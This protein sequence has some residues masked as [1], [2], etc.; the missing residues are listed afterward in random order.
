MVSFKMLNKISSFII[1]GMGYFSEQAF[2]SMHHDIRYFIP[3]KYFLK[4]NVKVT[5]DNVK[6][7]PSHKEYGE[8][9]RNFVAAYNA[10]HI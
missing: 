9:L 6:V 3:F 7:S 4:I 1:L 10:K 8:K 5:W 2:E